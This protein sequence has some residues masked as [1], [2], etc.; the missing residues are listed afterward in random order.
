MIGCGIPTEPGRGL[1]GPPRWCLQVAVTRLPWLLCVSFMTWSWRM[2]LC[3][4]RV[5]GVVFGSSVTLYS[6]QVRFFV[7]I[8]RFRY[9]L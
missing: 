3:S 9:F 8:K 2:A 4:S 5:H 6:P 7:L 1:R